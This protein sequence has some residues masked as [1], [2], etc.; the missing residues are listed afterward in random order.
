MSLHDEYARVTPYEMALPGRAFVREHMDAVAREGRHRELSLED[1]GTFRVLES[2]Q[3]A[4]E[5]IRI[6]EEGWGGLDP[7]AD[8][9]YHAFHFWRAGE[10]LFLLRLSLARA[11]VEDRSSVPPNETGAPWNPPLPAP[12]GYLQLP[13]N[14]FWVELEPEGVAES[15]DGIFWSPAGSGRLAFTVVAGMRDGRPGLGVLPLP[16]VPMEHL[17]LWPAVQGRREGQDFST[18]LPGGELDHLY[19]METPGEILKLMARTFQYM[20]E[21]PGSV[22]PSTVTRGKAEVG[23][24]GASPLPSTLPFRRVELAP[25]AADSQAPGRTSQ[26]EVN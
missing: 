9:L 4:L 18:T 21:V 19:S 3:L 13:R 10:P 24:D 22:S 26:P 23:G 11:L 20:A 6:Q 15:V 1:P 14:L 12:A 16:P 8:T 25:P 7:Y 2:T 17:P 5:K